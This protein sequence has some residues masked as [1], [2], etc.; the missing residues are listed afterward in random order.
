[1]SSI[2]GS[3]ERGLTMAEF[4]YGTKLSEQGGIQTYHKPWYDSAIIT[5]VA[6]CALVERRAFYAVMRWKNEKDADFGEWQVAVYRLSWGGA[7][8]T[9]TYK[10]QVES[11]GPCETTC[12]A[13]VL[14][15]A[16]R[17]IPH[18]PLSDEVR[19]EIARLREEERSGQTYAE[20]EA[21]RKRIHALDPLQTA[22]QWREACR[23]HL[24]QRQQTRTIRHGDR[25]RFPQ[26]VRFGSGETLDTFIVSKQGNTVRFLHPDHPERHYRKGA[27]W[28]APVFKPGMQN[29]GPRRGR[30]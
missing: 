18:P 5:E 19:A 30:C 17:L 29:P 8:G 27:G 2:S 7:G 13:H 11:M 25:V 23:A 20:R 10:D 28:N 26:P 14:D 24:A 4:F 22:R 21:I 3:F 6:A 9:I 12:T 15:V 16:D 1:M